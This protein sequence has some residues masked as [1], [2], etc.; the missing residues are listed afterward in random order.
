MKIRINGEYILVSDMEINPII[1]DDY[2]DYALDIRKENE[3]SIEAIAE[4]L[5]IKHIW[6]LD[7]SPSEAFNDLVDEINYIIDEFV[8][9]ALSENYTADCDTFE[10]DGI[11]IKWE[12]IS[13]DPYDTT[14]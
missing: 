8:D 13:F 6:D 3:T 2:L 11:T 10:C 7:T 12:I 4:K 14:T 5:V 1:S 9:R